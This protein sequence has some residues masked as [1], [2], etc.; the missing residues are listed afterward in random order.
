MRVQYWEEMAICSQQGNQ[1]AR[2]ALKRRRDVLQ[3]DAERE[4]LDKYLPQI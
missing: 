1:P 4:L 3:A 2:E